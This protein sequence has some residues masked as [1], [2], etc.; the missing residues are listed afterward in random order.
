MFEQG[1]VFLPFFSHCFPAARGIGVPP[2][3]G[4]SE[5]IIKK[6]Y[7]SGVVLEIFA[8]HVH[9]DHKCQ[10]LDLR[11]FR[12]FDISIE[13]IAEVSHKVRTALL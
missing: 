12:I 8:V 9:M 6:H 3:S 13:Q 2:V 10:R 4:S 5:I 11:V 7:S 1:A